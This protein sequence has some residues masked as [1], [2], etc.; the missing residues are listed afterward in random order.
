MWFSKQCHFLRGKSTVFLFLHSGDE[1]IL[2]IRFT[3]LMAKSFRMIYLHLVYARKT[4][5]SKLKWF[6]GVRQIKEASCQGRTGE[7]WCWKATDP[8][9]YLAWGSNREQR[10]VQ[11]PRDLHPIYRRQ[12]ANPVMPDSLV[13][14]L[15]S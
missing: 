9:S 4:Q 6:R 14:L 10:Q 8:G 1:G 7:A 13:P 15:L 11:W 3:W 12:N 2:S 5:G